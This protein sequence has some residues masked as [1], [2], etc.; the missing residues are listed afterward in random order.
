MDDVAGDLSLVDLFRALDGGVPT[1]SPRDEKVA[2]LGLEH[3][4]DVEIRTHRFK[5]RWEGRAWS[6][7]FPRLAPAMVGE[8][9]RRARLTRVGSSVVAAM[10]SSVLVFCGERLHPPDQILW[11][12]RRDDGLDVRTREPGEAG[13]PEAPT[14]IPDD[15]PFAFP[16]SWGEQPPF[17]PQYEDRTLTCPHCAASSARFRVLVSGSWVCPA[18]GRT[19]VPA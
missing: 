2:R 7:A 17:V 10:P 11:M 19:F 15:G 14:T 5:V 12:V 1:R 18:C 6:D 9:M 8:W 4:V 16:L 13:W 3:P